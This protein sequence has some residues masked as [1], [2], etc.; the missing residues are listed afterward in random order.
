MYWVSKG[1]IR[2]QFVIFS[3]IFIYLPCNWSNVIFSRV[4]IR[5]IHGGLPETK[6]FLFVFFHQS[7]NIYLHKLFCNREQAPISSSLN[8][9]DLYLVVCIF[10]V[11]AALIEYAVSNKN[12]IKLTILVQNWEVF[13]IHDFFTMALQISF[14][15]HG[16]VSE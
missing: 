10:F 3:S 11:F 2:F 4:H 15:G 8:A 14:D 9:V 5:S 13:H 12:A 6:I 1:C 7:N 16:A